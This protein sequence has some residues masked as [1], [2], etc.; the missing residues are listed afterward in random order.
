MSA[1]AMGALNDE[2]LIHT[3]DYL[4]NAIQARDYAA[5]ATLIVMVLPSLRTLRMAD[6][7]YSLHHLHLALRSLNPRTEWNN[8]HASD[9]L[10]QRLSHITAASFN[11]DRTSGVAYPS[12]G[13]RYDIDALL[14]LP[15]V[16]DWEFS[17]PDAS[18]LRLRGNNGVLGGEHPGGPNLAHLTRLVVRHSDVAF[19]YLQPFLG[20]TVQLQ[21][22]TYDFFFACK[23]GAD[24]PPRWLDLGAWSDSLPR[25]LKTLVL[26]VEN[27]EMGA[28]PFQQPRIGEKLFGYLD[29]T[30]H[31]NLHTVEVPFPFLTGDADFS[32]NTEIYPLFPLNLRHLSLR[33]DMSQAQHHFQFDTAR[34]PKA[35]TFQESEN[36]ARHLVNA[37]MDVSYMFHAAMILLNFAPNLETISVW[38]PADASLSWFDGQVSDFA[39]TCQNKSIKGLFIYPM[40]LRWK[41]EEH[42]NL[43]KEVTVYDP[44]RPSSPHHEVI[45]REERD[46]IPLGL[47]SQYHIHALRKHQVRLR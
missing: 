11:F 18:T 19:T 20:A 33:T 39:Q 7:Y 25:T 23:K 26:S 9:A 45:C 44:N 40:I 47:A 43:V 21:T 35:F 5:Y 41:K 3:T 34:L 46:G 15:C 30:R 2:S 13:L 31:E 37:R 6:L 24:A 4:T 17:I 29:L 14:N 1:L 38:Q 28:F 36:E 32:I 8:R 22:F 12:R 10:M 42:W 27:C 16:K